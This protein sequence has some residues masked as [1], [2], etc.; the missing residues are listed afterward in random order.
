ME[1]DLTA[2][3]NLMCEEIS[4]TGAQLWNK[5]KPNWTFVNCKKV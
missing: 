1:S 2:P 4:D 3:L 5:V